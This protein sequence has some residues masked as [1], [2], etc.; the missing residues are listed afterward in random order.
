VQFPGGETRSFL[1]DGD[2]LTMRAWCEADGA[3]P[4]GF[5]ECKGCVVA[6]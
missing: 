3:V 1:E 2:E 5:G 6:S 4:I